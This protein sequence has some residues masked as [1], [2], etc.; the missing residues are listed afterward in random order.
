MGAVKPGIA[1]DGV[2]TGRHRLDGQLQGRQGSQ[3]AD[4]LRSELIDGNAIGIELGSRGPGNRGSRQ[5]GGVLDIVAVPC[6]RRHV[7]QI[8]QDQDL[9]FE[10]SQGLKDGGKFKRTPFG[11]G[12]PGILVHTVGKEKKGHARRYSTGLASRQ[13]RGSFHRLE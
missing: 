3:V 5:E 7:R 8:R 6:V 1:N 10:G 12:R 11:S 2:D 4:P 13:R 9:I